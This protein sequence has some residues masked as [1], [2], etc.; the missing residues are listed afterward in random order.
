VNAPSLVA[1][2]VGLAGILGSLIWWLAT[3]PM[4]GGLEPDDSEANQE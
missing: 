1:L 4:A 2:K 3:L